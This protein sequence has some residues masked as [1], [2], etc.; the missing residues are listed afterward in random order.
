MLMSSGNS[1]GSN[2]DKYWFLQ[3]V[4]LSEIRWEE[5]PDHERGRYPHVLPSDRIRSRWVETG[6]HVNFHLG[7]ETSVQAPDSVVSWRTFDS[8]W[9]MVWWWWN[10]LRMD[11]PGGW[12]DLQLYVLGYFLGDCV[13]VSRILV[14][15]KE[16][17]WWRGK[18]ILRLSDECVGLTVMMSIV[19][20]FGV[21]IR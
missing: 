19:N 9:Y 1:F 10:Q 7:Q 8:S 16:F 11:V 17:W 13:Y 5:I 15:F 6:V 18:D 12:P 4:S 14:L 2:S 21:W 3:S 20:S